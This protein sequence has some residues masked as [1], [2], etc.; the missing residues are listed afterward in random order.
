M[1]SDVCSLFPQPCEDTCPIE[2][3][4][5]P[6]DIENQSGIVAVCRVCVSVCADVHACIH[7]LMFTCTWA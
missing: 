1:H 3:C 5:D 2:I 6:T 7:M 4:V